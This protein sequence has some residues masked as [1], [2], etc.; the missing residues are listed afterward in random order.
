MSKANN[1]IVDALYDLKI[2]VHN[3]AI[4]G[5]AK[6]VPTFITLKEF[7]AIVQIYINKYR[8]QIGE[9]A[10]RCVVCGEIIPEG[11]QVCSKLH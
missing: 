3:K 7:D 10:E 11:R 1:E 6:E 5:S 2:A 8:T 9:N 4:Y